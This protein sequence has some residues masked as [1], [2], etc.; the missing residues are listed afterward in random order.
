MTHD[1]DNDH[2][3]TAGGN[4]HLRV[5]ATLLLA[6]RP[7]LWYSTHN[8][9]R[10]HTHTH[11]LATS[12][13]WVVILVP[14][15]DFRSARCLRS[16]IWSR[17]HRLLMSTFAPSLSK[18]PPTPDFGRHCQEST[19][20]HTLSRPPNPGSLYWFEQEQRSLLPLDIINLRCWLLASPMHQPPSSMQ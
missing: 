13:P 1:T 17:D 11:A 14:E 8:L 5:L 2:H 9:L 6:G 3:S 19:H 10:K 15:L 12:K 4:A 16:L 18:V 7:N 20:T